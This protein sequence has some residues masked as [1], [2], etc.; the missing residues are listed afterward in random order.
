LEYELGKGIEKKF[1]E[2]SYLHTCVL[3]FL[4]IDELKEMRFRLG[5]IAALRDAA[6]Q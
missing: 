2:N 4:T 5:E 6:E 1:I 3:C